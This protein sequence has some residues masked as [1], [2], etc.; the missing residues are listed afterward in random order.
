MRRAL[1]TRMA[2][3]WEVLDRESI[4]LNQMLFYVL[5]SLHGL[6]CLITNGLGSQVLRD[7]T[8][9]SYYEFWMWLCFA[10]PLFTMVGK[11][12]RKSF[13]YTG[14]WMELI[15]DF[16]TWL[17]FLCY[18]AAIYDT[19]AWN[20]GSFAAT[21]AICCMFGTPL[22]IVRDIRRLRQVERIVKRAGGL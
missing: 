17:I 12:S 13:A 7:A 21:L 8:S 22:F 10:G 1:R 14:M 11:R 5:I 18:I 19:D 20:R 16:S 15:G 4:I 3:F 9:G 2:K 6:F